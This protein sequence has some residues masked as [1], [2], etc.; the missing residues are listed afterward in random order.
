MEVLNNIITTPFLIFQI[1]NNSKYV[2][3]VAYGDIIR[4]GL[5]ENNGALAGRT[6]VPQGGVTLF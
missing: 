4:T 5:Q 2:Y 1:Q 3:S 6:L